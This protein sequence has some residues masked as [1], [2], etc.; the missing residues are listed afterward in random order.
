MVL[1]DNGTILSMT[2]EVGVVIMV[3]VSTVNSIDNSSSSD[4]DGRIVLAVT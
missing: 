4:A 3:V 1:D 2:Q